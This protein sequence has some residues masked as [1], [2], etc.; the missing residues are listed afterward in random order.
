MNGLFEIKNR[1]FLKKTLTLLLPVVLQ[2][3]ITVGINFLDNLMIGS[4]GEISIASA[5]FGNQ[6]YN[7]FQFIC[8][9]LGSGAV[10]MS[11][12][13]WGRKE[14]DA[15]RTTASMALKVTAAICALFTLL[16]A[17]WPQV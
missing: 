13:F 10:V 7:F 4:F 5:A 9:G 17:G 3:L 16:C 1:A 15:M 8:M 12:Q 11:S 2:Q 14:Y 6:I